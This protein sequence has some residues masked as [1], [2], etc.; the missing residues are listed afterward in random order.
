MD[1]SRQV[2]DNVAL[3]I[4][5]AEAE[6][7]ARS[8]EDQLLARLPYMTIQEKQSYDHITGMY[9]LAHGGAVLG[10]PNQTLQATQYGELPY[11]PPTGPPLGAE[12]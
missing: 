3:Y 10:H 9:D 7:R 6:I 2:L 5:A 12:D 8:T 4:Q 11:P 1:V